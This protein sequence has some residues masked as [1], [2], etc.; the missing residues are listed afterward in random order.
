MEIKVQR[1]IISED[2]AR[3]QLEQLFDKLH[4]FDRLKAYALLDALLTIK[5]S[6][7]QK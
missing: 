5:A 6:A 3:K 4:E 1:R 2:D 7:L